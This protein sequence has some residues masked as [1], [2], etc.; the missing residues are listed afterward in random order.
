MYGPGAT[1]GIPAFPEWHT[2]SLSH[3]L[4]LISVSA[5]RINATLLTRKEIRAR[6]IRVRQPRVAVPR[7]TRAAEMRASVRSFG[8]LL[9]NAIESRRERAF[10]E[11][12]SIARRLD[13]GGDI[14]DFHLRFYRGLSAISFLSSSLSKT[15]VHES[16]RASSCVTRGHLPPNSRPRERVG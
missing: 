6:P 12:K 10:S 7:R 11:R 9:R 8:R 4:S 13:V 14:R 16:S 1:A 3:S 15:R 2:V 5:S